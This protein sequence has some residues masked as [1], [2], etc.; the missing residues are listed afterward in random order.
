MTDLNLASIP[1]QLFLLRN[2]A[3][4]SNRCMWIWI[5]YH[6]Y[7]MFF[8]FPFYLHRW[9]TSSDFSNLLMEKGFVCLYC[10]EFAACNISFNFIM[11]SC[12]FSCY[13]LVS[14]GLPYFS[15]FHWL[16]VCSCFEAFK[17]WIFFNSEYC[18]WLLYF[19]AWDVSFCH[20]LCL[21]YVSKNMRITKN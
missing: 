11:R 14:S 12:L 16:I 18:C 5:C 9:K 19:T 21:C 13:K 4:F 7:L 2:P 6:T 17:T 10:I 20:H 1:Q 3:I 8:A 15:I